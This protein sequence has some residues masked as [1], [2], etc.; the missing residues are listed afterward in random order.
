M[1]GDQIDNQIKEYAIAC[2]PDESCGLIIDSEYHPMKNLH[3]HK[4]DNFFV[5]PHEYPL[6]GSLQAV[7]HSHTRVKRNIPSWV[8]VQGQINT[9]VTWGLVSVTED[10]NTSEVLWWGKDVPIP[11]LIGR[12]FRLG[13]SGS[14]GAGDCFA[15][16]RDYFK[17]ERGIDI[18]D[19]ARDEA[20]ERK[21]T[22]NFYIQKFESWGFERIPKEMI[23]PGDGCL[24][25]FPREKIPK[26]AA[27]YVGNGLILHHRRNCLS[28]R[29]PITRY[30]EYITCWLRYVG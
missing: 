25:Q 16:V 24:I 29:E 22:E 13:P 26:H 3:P 20:W 7:V 17:L 10:L 2:F 30:Q 12:P 19:H 6:D 1:F 28:G 14:D 11:P 15:L 9:A 23:E 4:E 21:G 5:S 8:D 27:I 18:Q